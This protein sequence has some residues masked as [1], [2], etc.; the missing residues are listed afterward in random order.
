MVNCT[1]WKYGS[2]P[3]GYPVLIPGAKIIPIQPKIIIP[4]L[5]GEFVGQ[6]GL[7]RHAAAVQDQAPRVVIVVGENFA[8]V[9]YCGT[10]AAEM[11]F[12]EVDRARGQGPFDL[13]EKERVASD[14]TPEIYTG[15]ASVYF[16]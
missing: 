12:Q 15:S 6:V 14:F 5:A 1:H 4:P 13:H 11:V 8:D 2:R 9:I 16:T 3:T 7:R 10:H